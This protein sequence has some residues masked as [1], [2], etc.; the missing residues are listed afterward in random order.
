[1]RYQMKGLSRS[2][3]YGYVESDIKKEVKRLAR[4]FDCSMRLVINTALADALQ[5][6]AEDKFYEEAKS[7]EPRRRR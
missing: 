4:K 3:L 5:I 2:N 1:M 7:N 6:K